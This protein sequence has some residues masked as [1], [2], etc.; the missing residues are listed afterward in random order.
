VTVGTG[1]RLASVSVCRQIGVLIKRVFS[2]LEDRGRSDT[3]DTHKNHGRP[4]KRTWCSLDAMR[5]KG[6]TD[7]KSNISAGF[8]SEINESKNYEMMGN[9]LKPLPDLKLQRSGIVTETLFDRGMSPIQKKP[10][11]TKPAPIRHRQDRGGAICGTPINR[12]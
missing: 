4:V 11:L 10:P 2:Q 7:N 3:R 1:Y 8:S 6:G 12:D 9:R 5:L